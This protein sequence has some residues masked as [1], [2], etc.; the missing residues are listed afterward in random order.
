MTA[1]LAADEGRWSGITLILLTTLL[2]PTDPKLPSCP[3]TACLSSL[4]PVRQMS[5]GSNPHWL[6]GVEAGHGTAEQL[7]PERLRDKSALSTPLH[8][9][10]S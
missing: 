4:P 9:N 6:N 8:H 1:A 7:L 2:S 3:L 5:G 10:T